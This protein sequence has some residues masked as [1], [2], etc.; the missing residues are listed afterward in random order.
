M[1]TLLYLIKMA[2]EAIWA[3]VGLALAL[4]ALRNVWDDG[5]EYGGLIPV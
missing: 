2:T 4:R 3:G 1:A 5:G